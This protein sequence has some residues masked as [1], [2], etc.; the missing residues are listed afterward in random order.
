MKK[1]FAIS[2]LIG[3]LIS[4]FLM[5]IAWEENPRGELH[6]NGTIHWDAVLPILFSSWILSTLAVAAILFSSYLL[7]R[8][9]YHVYVRLSDNNG[10]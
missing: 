8:F 1:L 9:F 4:I 2:P 6:S 10:E 5:N 3:T 7:Y